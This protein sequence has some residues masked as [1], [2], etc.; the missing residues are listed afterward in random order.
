MTNEQT[1][2]MLLCIND[3]LRSAIEESLRY[4]P[5][6]AI[7]RDKNIFGIVTENIPAL[8]PFEKLANQLDVRIQYLIKE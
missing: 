1:A 5:N 2:T 4:L 6:E 7:A 3:Q 8:S